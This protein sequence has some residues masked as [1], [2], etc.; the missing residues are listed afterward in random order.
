MLPR[1]GHG[2]PFRRRPRP[3]RPRRRRRGPGRLRRGRRSSSTC[4]RGPMRFVQRRRSS[5]Q[6]ASPPPSSCTSRSTSRRRSRCS[7]SRPLPRP[8]RR[9]R[10]QRPLP[11]QPAAA[12]PV[13]APA[14]RRTRSVEAPGARADSARGPRPA[15][16]RRDQ[17][18]DRPCGRGRPRASGARAVTGLLR[19]PPR[20]PGDDLGRRRPS[21]SRRARPRSAVQLTATKP[22]TATLELLE[23]MGGK[24][25]ARAHDRAAG[26]RAGRLGARPR[27]S[28]RS[29]SAARWPASRA[30]PRSASTRSRASRTRTAERASRSTSSRRP[31]RARPELA[32]RPRL[33]GRRARAAKRGEAAEGRPARSP[34]SSC[35]G[36]PVTTGSP[37][38]R[39]ERR[40]ADGLRRD[41]C[42][43]AGSHV[44]VQ[45]T[46]GIRLFQYQPAT[47]GDPSATPDTLRRVEYLE[48]MLL[49]RPARRRP[50][51]G[52]RAGQGRRSVRRLPLRLRVAP[53]RA[54]GRARRGVRAGRHDGPAARATGSSSGASAR[55]RPAARGE[56][57][58]RR[59]G[60]SRHPALRGGAD[61]PARGLARERPRPPARGR[62]SATSS[63]TTCA[64]RCGRSSRRGGSSRAR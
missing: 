21:R 12:P 9:R 36:S 1:P 32:R 4:P 19:A 49:S 54:D 42:S 39:R 29:R 8:A 55:L 15:Q 5:A 57:V 33:A 44:V 17:G 40:A 16:H 10:R 28:R 47:T 64:A 34:S 18:R 59:G 41:A 37:I 51:A 61:A 43:A 23:E 63:R 3:R 22:S 31:G 24:T 26:T 11:H 48:R 27:R 2:V 58:V 25:S 62:S 60:R 13:P 56:A 6:G 14:P 20:R 7:R 46:T 52:L 30:A 38:H 45:L 53:A 50:R 35:R